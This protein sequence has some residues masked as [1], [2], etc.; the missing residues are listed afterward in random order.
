M[1]CSS[2]IKETATPGQLFFCSSDQG[3]LK[4][5]LLK[6]VDNR[7][8]LATLVVVLPLLAVGQETIPCEFFF[9]LFVIQRSL[10]KFLVINE[11]KVIYHTV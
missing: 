5:Q 6:V 2:Y 1:G 4:M 7:Q 3:I 8:I 11:L 9:V 10:L